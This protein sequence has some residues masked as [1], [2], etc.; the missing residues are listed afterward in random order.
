MLDEE[1]KNNLKKCA[2][3]ALCL[4]NCP[5]YDIKKDENN[6]SRGLICKLKACEKGLLSEK[7]VSKDL[8]IFK[9]KI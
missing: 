4:K 9:T 6:T 7:E 2:R 3:C 5:I 1:I 8:K